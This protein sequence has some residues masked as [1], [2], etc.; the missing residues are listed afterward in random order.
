MLSR[1]K[2]PQAMGARNERNPLASDVATH[3][4]TERGE[5]LLSRPVNLNP[6]LPDKASQSQ[7]GLRRFEQVL[8]LL[9][10]LTLLRLIH[11]A[12]GSADAV[13]ESPA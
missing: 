13:I 10:K 6:L 11:C 2:S 7:S 5:L 4:G 8:I 9:D 3:S 1:Y 12:E